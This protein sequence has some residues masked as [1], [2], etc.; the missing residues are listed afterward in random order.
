MG[1]GRDTGRGPG[2]LEFIALLAPA[3]LC[4]SVYFPGAAVTNDHKL[5]GN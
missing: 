1:G 5:D 3:L 2:P 4:L